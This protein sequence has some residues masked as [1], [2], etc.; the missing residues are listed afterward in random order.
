MLSMEEKVHAR[1]QFWVARS[2]ILK[3]MPGV[4][5]LPL[6]ASMVALKGTGFFFSGRGKLVNK[7]FDP[8]LIDEKTYQQL[9]KDYAKFMAFE[10]NKG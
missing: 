3:V 7:E 1:K 9:Q 8:S 10:A 2:N 6:L 5:N 4:A